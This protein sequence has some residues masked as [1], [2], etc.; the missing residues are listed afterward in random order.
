MQEMFNRSLVD[1]EGIRS[2]P[3][4][5]KNEKM[6]LLRSAPPLYDRRT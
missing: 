4:V 2:T 3:T 5:G 6:E 1:T